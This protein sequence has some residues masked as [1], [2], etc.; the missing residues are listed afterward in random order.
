[1]LPLDYLCRCQWAAASIA[2]I[3]GTSLFVN[4]QKLTAT[5]IR[6]QIVAYHI[7]QEPEP[8]HRLEWLPGGYPPI[9]RHVPRF[10]GTTWRPVTGFLHRNLNGVAYELIHRGETATLYVMPA[11]VSDLRS[12]PPPRLGLATGGWATAAWQEMC[13]WCAGTSEPIGTSS[14]SRP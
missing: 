7:Q 9:S 10:P 3:V 8:V 11:L 5:Q 6:E 2:A 14:S 12:T 4:G 13:W 1:M